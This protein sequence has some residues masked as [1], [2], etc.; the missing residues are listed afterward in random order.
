MFN[1]FGALLLGMILGCGICFLLYAAIWASSPIPYY[2]V[3]TVLTVGSLVLIWWLMF[4][5]P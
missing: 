5:G 1:P 3:G 4:R 2:I